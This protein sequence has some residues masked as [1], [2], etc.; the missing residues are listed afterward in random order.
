MPP[1][2]PLETPT[3]P[4]RIASQ[5]AK[6]VTMT[7]TITPLW[8]IAT[9]AVLAGIVAG[10]LTLGG[11]SRPAAATPPAKQTIAVHTPVQPAMSAAVSTRP[12]VYLTFD[13]GPHP[14]YT[15][16]ILAVLSRYG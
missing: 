10:Y 5:Q 9:L 16:Q 11:R 14:T 2:Q 3:R 15:P 1:F 12:I 7:R 6:G 13:D 4:A 8:R